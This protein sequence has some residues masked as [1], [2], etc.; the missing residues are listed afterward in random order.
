MK[1]MRYHIPLV[2]GLLLSI[3]A[4]T[5][6]GVKKGKEG[7]E[8]P[9]KKGHDTQPSKVIDSNAVDLKAKHEVVDDMTLSNGI[10]IKWFEHGKGDIIKAGDM[11]DVN[12]R[13]ELKNGELIDAN[14]LRSL[15]SFPYM[16][17]FQMQPGWDPALKEMRIGDH[18]EI[19]IP[20]QLARGAKAVEGL[21]PEKAD[22]ILKI[23]VMGLH[24][25]DK[26][27][28]GGIRIWMF[29]E[30]KHNKELFGPGKSI[31][32]HCYLSS[33]SSPM[34]Y[35]TQ[36]ENNPFSYVYDDPGL[37]PGLRKALN[38]A[39][40]ADLML[41]HIPAAEAYGAQGYHDVVKPNEDIFGR[42]FVM[43]VK[44]EPKQE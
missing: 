17:G 26:V 32:F 9:T 31:Y 8:L 25:P 2:I 13:V 28:E 33:P 35:D 21:L 42:I 30:N 20:Y 7:E 6:E 41:V 3:A 4:C 43:E 27:I 29:A 16:V 11:V 22:H 34:Y 44:E 15:P 14:E 18:V 1:K 40:K 24:E 23:H 12:Y 38:N 36:I 39:K 10:K 37:V 19:Y 5:P